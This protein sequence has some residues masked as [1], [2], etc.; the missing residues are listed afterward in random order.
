MIINNVKLELEDEVVRGSLSVEQGVIQA[1][2]D[3]ASQLPQVIDGESGWLMPGMV[4]LHIDNLDKFFTPRPKVDWPAHSAMSSHDALMIS[5]GITT[6]LDAIGVGDVRDGC[7]HMENLSKMLQAI[8]YSNR[9]G[10]NRADHLVHLR[11]EFPMTRRLACLS[12]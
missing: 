7:H 3:T 1:F 4:E 8:R 11:C 9:H 6:V 5:S 10:L 12:S 2:S